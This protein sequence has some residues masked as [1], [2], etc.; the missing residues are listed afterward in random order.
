[1]Q[2]RSDRKW[3]KKDSP[4]AGPYTRNMFRTKKEKPSEYR[5]SG[6]FSRLSAVILGMEIILAERLT[7]LSEA[8]VA[9]LA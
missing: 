5:F 8:L 2:S 3:R 7:R 9:D 4:K 6:G 1:M